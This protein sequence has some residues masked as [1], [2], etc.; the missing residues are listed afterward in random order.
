[1]NLQVTK[2]NNIPTNTFVTTGSNNAQ[3]IEGEVELTKDTTTIK[4]DLTATKV[5]RGLSFGEQTEPRLKR[6]LV[7]LVEDF[8]AYLKGFTTDLLEY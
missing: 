3:V 2:L 1:V 6:R 4:V 8:I 5:N 7:T